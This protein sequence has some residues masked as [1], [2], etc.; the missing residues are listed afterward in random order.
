[1]LTFTPSP[2]GGSAPAAMGLVPGAFSAVGTQ[3]PGTNVATVA[4]T[5]PLCCTVTVGAV[6]KPLVA[7]MP[8]T[9]MV[10]V[11]G[12]PPGAPAGSGA[13]DVTV[14]V[15]G[16]WSSTTVVVTAAWLRC[17]AAWLA[18]HQLP[19]SSMYRTAT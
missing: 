14:K 19:N 18:Q 1:M 8:L 16:V 13:A 9:R 12:M 10:T 4:V 5:M 3:L 2:A 7:S 17:G 15:G 11:C 6:P